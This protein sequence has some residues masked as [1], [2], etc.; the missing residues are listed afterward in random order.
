MVKLSLPQATT[1]AILLQQAAQF[2]LAL[3]LEKT[4]VLSHPFQIIIMI[5]QPQEHPVLA[6]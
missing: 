2:T 3:S 1:L 4:K 6:L 5:T